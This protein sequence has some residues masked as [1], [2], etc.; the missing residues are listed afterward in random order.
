MSSFKEYVYSLKGYQI[1]SSDSPMLPKLYCVFKH[2]YWDYMFLVK[3]CSHSPENSA[4]SST[5]RTTLPARFNSLLYGTN[6]RHWNDTGNLSTSSHL[7]TGKL[8]TR[9][10][11]HLSHL[12]SCL[13]ESEISF[14]SLKLTLLWMKLIPSHFC[15]TLFAQLVSFWTTSPS[16][17]EA[18]SSVNAYMSPACPPDGILIS[19]PL[20]NPLQSASCRYH[21][22]EATL[23]TLTG[24][25]TQT[26]QS[27]SSQSSTPQAFPHTERA[28]PHAQSLGPKACTWVILLQSVRTSRYL[29]LHWYPDRFSVCHF[30]L[31]SLPLPSFS[32][33]TLPPNRVQSVLPK[34]A[35][36]AS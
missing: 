25:F 19:H 28:L 24:A 32:A 5:L 17:S 20:L 23:A 10:D 26:T 6:Q 36:R 1:D 27:S 13:G 21:S 29:Y 9:A 7:Y 22:T 33:C 18:S 3:F 8:G 11:I 15:R 16:L 12:P 30:W 31:V 2:G 14:F 34:A 4:L 35:R